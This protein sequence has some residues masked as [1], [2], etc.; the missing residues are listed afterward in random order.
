VV[1]SNTNKTGP[2]VSVLISTYNRPRYFHEALASVL[3]QNYSNLQVIV[4]NDGGEDVSDV[5]DSFSDS[6]VVFINRKEN[7]GKAFSLNE[8]LNQAEGK[9]IAYLDD[10]DLYY[11]HH[12]E[13][14]VTALENRTDCQVAYSDLYKTYCKVLP[15]GSR[16]ILS[17]IVEISRDFNRFFMLYFNHVLHV[18]L[19]HHRDLIDKTG[20][21][22]EQLNILIDWD[23]TRRLVFFSDFYHANEITGE[24]YSPVEGSDRISVLQRQNEGEF[25]RNLLAIRTKRPAKPWSKLEDMSI[26]FATEHFNKQAGQ[27]VSSIWRYTFYPY[28]LYLPISRAEFDRLKIDMPNVV[29]VPVEPT[30]PCSQRIDAALAVCEGEYVAV[31][32]D[33]LP[34]GEMWV[35]KP[36]HALI[37][38]RTQHEGFKL[39]GSND[40]CWAAVVRKGELVSARKRFPQLSV[41]ESLKAVGVV[42]REPDFEELPFQFDELLGCGKSAARNGKWTEAAEMFEYAAEHY[43]NELWMKTLAARCFY[44]AGEHI[45]ALKLSTQVNA[46]RPT[47]DTLLLE[48]KVKREK[49]EFIAAIELLRT[50]EHILVGDS[51]S[52]FRVEVSRL[53]S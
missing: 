1:N 49:N 17:K 22:N 15:D 41:P 24:F 4:V 39:I 40:D 43:R 35:E 48:A 19:M 28:K 29:F 52:C 37:N 51:E 13:T 2:K 3:R 26:I 25:L 46:R 6:R 30:S 27:S 10:D 38:S 23:M 5:V 36:L 31:V 18:S 47:V 44:K 34:I 45:K 8:A 42:L 16:Q 20:L 12:V 21:Y 14:L 11:P 33:G 32:P 9:Y 7:K 53:S 50:A